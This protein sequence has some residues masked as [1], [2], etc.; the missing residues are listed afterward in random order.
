MRGLAGG[1]WWAGACGAA[2]GVR[3]SAVQTATLLHTA[4]VSS[5]VRGIFV[6][7]WK[8][9]SVHLPPLVSSTMVSASF[10]KLSAASLLRMN[11]RCSAG[12]SMRGYPLN[13]R[14]GHSRCKRLVLR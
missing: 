12:G 2:R 14:R 10:G 7:K 3:R 5:G 6:R 11:E 8:G 1:G 4:H 13:T 9:G